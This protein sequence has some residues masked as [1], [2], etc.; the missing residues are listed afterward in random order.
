HADRYVPSAVRH[1]HDELVEVPVPDHDVPEPAAVELTPLARKGEERRV[2]EKLLEEV[3]AR[4]RRAGDPVP[5]SGAHVLPVAEG[6]VPDVRAEVEDRL[7]KRLVHRAGDP[8]AGAFGAQGASIRSAA[9]TTFSR[10]RGRTH[11]RNRL[12]SCGPG[13]RGDGQDLRDDQ[14]R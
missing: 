5:L 2:D 14:R 8:T 12:R 4:V 11:E 13:D 6:D 3:A 9:R 1:R 10:W 7:T